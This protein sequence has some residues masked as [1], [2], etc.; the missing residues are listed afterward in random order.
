V[1][2]ALGERKKIELVAHDNKKAD[3]IEWATFNRHLL[4]AHELARQ[5]PRARSWRNASGWAS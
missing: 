1:D 3:L 2:Q 4:E 5:G